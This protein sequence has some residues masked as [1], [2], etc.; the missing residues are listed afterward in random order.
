MR[1]PTGAAS[2]LL[3]Q[4]A[5]R[6]PLIPRDRPTLPPLAQQLADIAALARTPLDHPDAAVRIAAAHNKAAL[7]AS[8]GGHDDLARALCWQHHHRYA[9]RQPWTAVLARR[10]L[11]PV[12]NLARLHIRAGH[13]DIAVEALGS[14]L[15]AVSQGGITKIDGYPIDLGNTIATPDDRAEI[16]RWIWTVTLAEGVRAFAR[17]G[18][19][20][21]ALA[22]ARYHRGIGATLLD[23][24]QIA[25]IAHGLRGDHAHATTMLATTM[26]AQPW[27]QTVAYLLS[28]LISR[29]S[30]VT[31]PHDANQLIDPQHTAGQTP[32]AAVFGLEVQLATLE[33]VDEPARAA[34]LAELI[35]ITAATTDASIARTVVTHPARRHLPAALLDHLTAVHNLATTS[36]AAGSLGDALADALAGHP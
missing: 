25:I 36:P 13:P 27:Q 24:R 34:V 12:V 26:P 30:G 19:W 8:N 15:S 9:D 28:L 10:A 23:G 11:E 31:A 7:V 4:V 6:F 18:R 16:R 5:R 35:R 3:E 29:R 14:L 21:D 33:L 17:V 22:H 20:N 32:T 1:T 2:Q